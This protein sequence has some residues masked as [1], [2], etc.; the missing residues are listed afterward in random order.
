MSRSTPTASSLWKCPP[1]PALVAVAGDPDHHSVPVRPLREELQRR[2]LAAELVLGVVQVREVLDLR[3]RQ[4]PAHR[5]AEREA[6][7]R[8]LVEQRVEDA[9]RAEARVQPACDPVDAA[10]H[11]DV[12]AEEQSTRVVLEHGGETG[13]DPL[14]ERQRLGTCERVREP[15]VR[16]HA[17]RAR[18]ERR[19]DLL[20]R[21]HLRERGDL[22]RQLAHLVACRQ[23]VVRELLTGRTSGGDEP[24]RGAE[25]RVALVVRADR[26]RRAI[27]HL[28]VGARVAQ[29]AHGAEVE[30]GGTPLLAHPLGQL[31]RDAEHLRGIVPV[32][33]LVADLLAGGERR[34]DPARPGSER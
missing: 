22:E 29:V 33:D 9:T 26:L 34:L 15:P 1:K 3:D 11:G 13:V 16:D 25:N 24:A 20:G 18:R 2:R 12:L 8:R 31:V 23:V 7:D 4:E 32:R 19:H 10:L 14:R 21:R 17:G 30:D 5:G 6:E 28:G 27:R